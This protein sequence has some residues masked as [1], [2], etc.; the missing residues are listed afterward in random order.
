MARG[1]LL[2]TIDR[3]KAI[4]YRIASFHEGN[5]PFTGLSL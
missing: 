5:T 1:M 4:S 2:M 3:L